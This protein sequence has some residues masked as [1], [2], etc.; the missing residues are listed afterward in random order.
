MNDEYIA[1]PSDVLSRTRP[2]EPFINYSNLSSHERSSTRVFKYIFRI[3]MGAAKLYSTDGF[4]R[5]GF[6]RNDGP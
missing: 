5:L 2:T 1:I 6:H 3:Q 4:S